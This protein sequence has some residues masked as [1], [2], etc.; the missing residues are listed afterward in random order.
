MKGWYGNTHKHSL[1]SRG[2]S[3]REIKYFVDYPEVIDYSE[4]EEIIVGFWFASLKNDFSKFDFDLAFKNMNE[5]LEKVASEWG[6]LGVE[7][8]K[9]H[10][11]YG[12][13]VDNLC[14]SDKDFCEKYD[15]MIYGDSSEK[16]MDIFVFN[17]SH[18]FEYFD[19]KE[20]AIVGEL[21]KETL[22]PPEKLQEKII[23]MDKL[24]NLTH[25]RGSIWHGDGMYGFID[26][27][28]LRNKVEMTWTH[29]KTI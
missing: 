2:I 25:D 21:Y 20:Y 24:V 27:P 13:I 5:I 10:V 12:I 4:I 14:Y 7:K 28:K 16:E 9:E 8:W 1:A 3:T 26:I 17:Y 11:D 23:L 15:D 29:T 19:K 18:D 22:N 6:Y